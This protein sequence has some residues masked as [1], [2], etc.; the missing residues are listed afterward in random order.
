MEGLRNGDESPE[1]L[2]AA[3][4]TQALELSIPEAETALQHK[5]PFQLLIATILSAQCTDVRVN[6]VTPSLFKAFPDPETLLKGDPEHLISL[7]R[8]TGF[9]RNKAK[10]IIGCAKRL[11][12]NFEGKVPKTFEA[13]VSLPGVGRK[14]ANVVL[15]SAF[16]QE[17]IVVDT[18][19]RRVANRLGLSPSKDPTQIEFDLGRLLPKEKWT[20]TAHRLLLHGRRTC[21]ARRPLCTSCVLYCLCPSKE[22]TG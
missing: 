20:A 1:A 2:R 11:V 7:I 13:L 10:N 3:A 4:I 14:T 9:Y 18:H 16:G 15:G 22:K 8:S 6:Q 12:E 19:V 21:K 5:T 17:A